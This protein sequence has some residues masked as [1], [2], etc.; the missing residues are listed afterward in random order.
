MDTFCFVLRTQQKIL[1]LYLY[2]TFH[3]I[4]RNCFCLFETFS[5]VLERKNFTAGW[6]SFSESIKRLFSLWNWPHTFSESDCRWN[7]LILD[8]LNSDNM[9]DAFF[10]TVL[11]G[12][13]FNV[14]LLVSPCWRLKQIL[15]LT[16]VIELCNSYKFWQHLWILLFSIKRQF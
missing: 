1:M 10:S 4:K 7:W 2:W 9:F 3:L 13:N 6:F 14:F 11:Y 16:Q 12:I 5:F 8:F 15:W